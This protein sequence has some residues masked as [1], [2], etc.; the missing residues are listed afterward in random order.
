[1]RKTANEGLT[2]DAKPPRNV[3]WYISSTVVEYSLVRMSKE[4]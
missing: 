3:V 1:M 2:R 4:A